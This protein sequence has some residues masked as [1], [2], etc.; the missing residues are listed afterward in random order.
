M[1]ISKKFDKWI[2]DMAIWSWVMVALLA[3]FSLEKIIK[4]CNELF[5]KQ[6]I[7]ETNHK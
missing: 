2:S 1:K 5:T 3:L 4:S 7:E 6:I